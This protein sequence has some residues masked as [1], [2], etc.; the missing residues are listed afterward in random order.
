MTTTDKHA[1]LKKERR[2]LWGWGAWAVMGLVGIAVV[3]TAVRGHKVRAQDSGLSARCQL[4]DSGCLQANTI[5]ADR[6]WASERAKPLADRISP[7]WPGVVELMTWENDREHFPH[8]PRPAQPDAAFLADMR[9]AITT[10]PSAVLRLVEH[11]LAGIQL[12]ADLGSSGYSDYVYDP[13]GKPTGAMVV[14]DAGVLQSLSANGWASWKESTPFANDRAWSLQAQLEEEGSNNRIQALQYILLHE[15]AHV[16]ASTYAVHPRWDMA[17]AQ[18]AKQ[19]S[20]AFFN[21][22][23]SVDAKSGQ[24]A[25]RFD[26]TFAQR[27]DIRYYVGPSMPANSMLAAYKMLGATNFPTLYAATKPG[28]DFAESFASYVHV[29]QQKRPWTITIRH[30]GAADFVFKACW[31]EPRCADKRK[32]LDALLAAP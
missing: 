19:G 9:A 14:L 27:R 29:V 13:D 18:A 3:L 32:L 22:S 8:R 6:F 1:M 16:L 30:D 21:L 25:S 11:R 20:F 24:Y 15:F 26:D 17:P 7:A 10:L 28:D 5:T 31:D 23:W 12:V 2:K 4:G